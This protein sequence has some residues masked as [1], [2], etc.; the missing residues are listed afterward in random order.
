MKESLKIGLDQIVEIGES[1]ID[2]KLLT[3]SICFCLCINSHQCRNKKCLKMFCYE[4]IIQAKIQFKNCPFCRLNIDFKKVDGNIGLIYEK[5]MVICLEENSCKKKFSIEDYLYSHSKGLDTISKLLSCFNC[6]KTNKFLYSCKICFKYS[7]LTCE[8]MKLCYNCKVTICLICVGDIN[9]KYLQEVLCGICS[10][11]CFY[12]CKDNILSEGKYVCSL[13]NKIICE[14]CYVVCDDCNLTICLDSDNCYRKKKENCEKCNNISVTQLYNKCIHE[15]I[16]TCSKC[17]QQCELK[18]R[19][20]C[21]KIVTQ[22]NKC[23]KCEKGICFRNCSIRCSNCKKIICKK[24]DEFC[25][26]CKGNFCDSCIKKCIS[27]S[28]FA[29]CI[30]CNIS[31]LKSCTKCNELLCINCWNVCNYCVSVYCYKHISS[32]LEC[33]ENSCE[34]HLINCLICKEKRKE[35]SNFKKLC[36][37]NCTLKCSFCENSSNIQ[38][39]K[40]IHPIVSS[41]NCG[42][43]VCSKCVKLCSK[44]P[45]KVVK[46]CPLCIVDYYYYMCKQCKCYLCAVCSGYCKLCEELYCTSHICLNC[47]K[48]VNCQICLTLQIFKCLQC[49]D[50]IELSNELKIDGLIICSINCLEKFSLNKNLNYNKLCVKCS[51]MKKIDIKKIDNKLP[52]FQT[53]NT[54]QMEQKNK[55]LNEKK[56]R[57]ESKKT[58]IGCSQACVIS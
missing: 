45:N 28:T 42:H 19:D 44:C 40:N 25:I 7:C 50:I 2:T 20:T 47:K 55:K 8:T 29:S 41:L 22:N 36:L 9:N 14:K 1:L 54:I 13:C 17:Y 51:Q 39:L 38:C 27:C 33:E 52:C 37:K 49:S 56:M 58:D 4:C 15:V 11:Y 57:K 46:S 12:C 10:C 5:I 53:N 32:C 43:N 21:G 18:S 48:S 23:K 30:N 6:K 26:Q 35:E 31:T 16:K 34:N 3:C 24:C